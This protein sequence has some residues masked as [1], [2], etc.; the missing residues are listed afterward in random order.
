[1]SLAEWFAP[2]RPS[3]EEPKWIGM[4]KDKI[5]RNKLSKL[6]TKVLSDYSPT[7]EKNKKFAFRVLTEAFPEIIV[8]WQWENIYRQDKKPN[9]IVNEILNA[10]KIRAVSEYGGWGGKRGKDRDWC[11]YGW[12]LA[13][14]LKPSVVLKRLK[15]DIDPIEFYDLLKCAY[16]GTNT[17]Y[18]HVIGHK[19]VWLRC[20]KCRKF[21]LVSS[22]NFG[23]AKNVMCSYCANPNLNMNLEDKI[24]D[25]I[26][27]SLR[28]LTEIR[29][30][31]WKSADINN[32]KHVKVLSILF[33]ETYAYTKK[34]GKQ[35]TKDSIYKAIDKVIRYLLNGR[36]DKRDQKF[37]IDKKFYYLACLTS[38]IDI[39]LDSRTP[40]L[41]SFPLTKS[42]VEQGYTTL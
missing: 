10:K 11:L 31:F 13:I 21:T 22:P 2:N 9:A 41:D 20:C 5:N 15:V 27:W 12:A 24:R 29:Y 4:E 8:Y 7:T 28:I 23:C 1:M 30:L 18:H 40:F 6:I 19:G 26:V 33:P 35:V 25:A 34:K 32:Q 16:Q 37:Y 14:L 17:N 42:A 38:L 3:T 36:I 39:L